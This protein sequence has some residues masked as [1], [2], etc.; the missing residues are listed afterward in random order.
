MLK[1]RIV[2]LCSAA[3]IA[4]VMGGCGMGAMTTK[5]TEF[6]VPLVAKEELK[7]RLGSPGL[8]ILDV[9]YPDHWKASRERIPGA[10]REEAEEVLSWAKKY[11]KNDEIAVY[12]D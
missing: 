2:H 5:A 11:S 7:T 3:L 4:A 6:D 9:R 1:A 10:I 8:V 12:C